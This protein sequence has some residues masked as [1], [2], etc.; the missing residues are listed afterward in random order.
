MDKNIQAQREELLEY[1]Y[2]LS[3]LGREMALTIARVAYHT[4]K[5]MRQQFTVSL[6]K[7][8]LL[9]KSI[10]AQPQEAAV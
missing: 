4:E 10:P 7:S 6:Q 8:G 9:P 1:F 2:G 5:N 3:E